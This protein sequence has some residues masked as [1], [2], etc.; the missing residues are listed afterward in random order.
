MAQKKKNSRRKESTA[1]PANLN[2]LKRSI[3]ELFQENAGASL[4]VKQIFAK[5]GIRDKN[6]KRETVSYLLELEHEGILRQLRNGH[7]MTAESSLPT[8]GL[9]GKV[10]H[11]NQ[12][13]AYVILQDNS[14]EEKNDIWVKTDDLMNAIDGDIVEVKLKKNSRGNKPEGKVVRLVERSK[15]EFVGKIEIFPKYAFVVPDNRKIHVDIFVYPEKIGDAK[16]ND[17]VI[18]KIKEWHGGKAK[19]PVGQVT[20]ILGPAGEN[21]AEIHSIM[22]EF[23]LPFEFPKHVEQA[24]EAIDITIT[25]EEIKKRKDFREITTFTIDPEDA[26]DFDDAISIQ[27][28]KNGNYEIGV[29]IAD[30]SHYVEPGSILDEEAIN[31]ATSVYLVDRTIPMLPEKL[32]NGVCSLRPN[33]EKL[34]FSAVF[35][36]DEDA[37]VKKSWFGRTIIYSDRRFTYEEAQ[38]RIETKEGDFQEE[39]NILNG[40]AKK[41]KVKRFKNGAINFETV[42]V[43]FKLDE[44]GKPLGIIPKV[45][46]DAHKLVE[47]FML[48]ANKSVAQYVYK[49]DQGND[50]FVY[51]VHDSP[52][53]ERLDSFTKF[54]VKFGHRVT[55]INSD[56][57]KALNQLMEDIQGKPEQNVLESLAI[58]SMSKAAYVT[59]PKGHF[60]LAFDHYTHFT[61]PIRR[62]PDVMVH[63]LMQHYLLNKKSPKKDE[64]VELCKHS[65]EREKRAA[66]AE[67]ASI[68]FKQVE[69]MQSVED[70]AF[71]GVIAGVTEFGIFVE[72]TETKCE[73]MVRASSMTDD[74]YEFDE[75]NYCMIGK[76]NKRVFTLGDRVIVRVVGTD[77]NRRT[78]DLEFVDLDD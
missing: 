53:P 57:A 5:A 71:D 15:K 64:Y 46:K 11:V 25:Q 78:I 43:K 13:F 50:T 61:S 27:K 65:S 21:E 59:D 68:K 56:V 7:F 19:N 34:T 55:G 76:R 9:I 42:E 14:D 62:Y 66:D 8:S 32:S 10:D 17:K 33:E 51:R 45:R 39:I 1:K 70:K 4:S 69:Y 36:I 6:S 12:R 38:E 60:G 52:D 23:D 2:T 30:V 24:A 37:K 74:F 35:E 31:R 40:L 63:R 3:Q 72:I 20:K 75:K 54:A 58:R 47:E 29:H 18:V 48:L 26:K 41:L 44:N 67:R 22:A 28:L 73:G 77:I 16:T 49:L